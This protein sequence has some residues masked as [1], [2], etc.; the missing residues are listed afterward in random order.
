MTIF[1]FLLLRVCSRYLHS[2][3]STFK[4]Y[5]FSCFG[6]HT[7]ELLILKVHKEG[8]TEE[9]ITNIKV[10]K[11][12][13]ISKIYCNETSKYNRWKE[14]ARL[15]KFYSGGCDMKLIIFDVYGTLI[16]TGTGSLDAVK[17]ILA[18][19]DKDINP[20]EFYREWKKQHRI[21]MDNANAKLFID[22][23]TI[24]KF[25]LEQLYLKYYISR[26]FCSDVN[27]MLDTLGKRKCFDETLSSV[28]NL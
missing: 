16:S 18:L 5:I 23:E 8:L 10:L 3:G 9:E 4:K 19:Q 26:D 21:H 24:F 27:I 11:Y 13:G 28:E 14:L 22:E 7:T 20:E 25:D 1:Y 6:G 12:K 2:I 15:Q 17:K